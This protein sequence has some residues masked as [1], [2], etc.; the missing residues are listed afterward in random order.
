V[1]EETALFGDTKIEYF[2]ECILIFE[3]V[4]KYLF[5]VSSVSIASNKIA[6]LI[7]ALLEFFIS[8]FIEKSPL[9]MI[10]EDLKCFS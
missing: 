3:E 10:A 5:C 6:T 4:I 8:I 9:D 1:P 7:E 2:S